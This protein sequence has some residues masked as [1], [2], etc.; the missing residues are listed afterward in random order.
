MKPAEL[1]E[2]IRTALRGN[3]PEDLSPETWE[4]IRAM[5]LGHGDLYSSRLEH[6]FAEE[7]LRRCG[8]TDDE[9]FEAL[10]ALHP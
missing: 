3:Y 1:A 5:Y 2:D 9:I 6:L 10:G 4:W 7:F 8:L